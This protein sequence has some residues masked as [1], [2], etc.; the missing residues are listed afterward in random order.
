MGVRDCRPSASHKWEKGVIEAAVGPLS[1][2]VDISGSSQRKVHIDHLMERLPTKTLV[3]TNPDLPMEAISDGDVGI[4]SA[5][6]EAP[7]EPTTTSASSD[8]EEPTVMP[9]TAIPE[10]EE[11]FAQ[12]NPS[13]LTS[14]PP[15]IVRRS[16]VVRLKLLKDLL[17]NY[18]QS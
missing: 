8:V 15:K 2:I 4:S 6:T 10:R 5:V 18:E 14:S 13:P 17:R 3:Y 12:A 1:Y 7:Q 16:Q 9:S 11:A